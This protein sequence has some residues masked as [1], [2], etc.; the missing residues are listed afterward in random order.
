M[1]VDEQVEEVAARALRATG[2]KKRK[3]RA[4][5]R[6]FLRWGHRWAALILGVL[7]VVITTSG[8]ILL[9]KPEIF[10]FTHRDLFTSTVSAQQIDIAT[11]VDI[12]NKFD[13]D[14]K[15]TGATLAQGVYVVSGADESGPAVFI[16]PGTG[17]V[18]GTGRDAGGFIGV[19]DNLHECALTCQDYP[20]YVAWMADTPL[21]FLA[22]KS[23]YNGDDN[24][25]VPGWQSLSEMSI[26]NMI[27]GSLGLLL[28]LLAVSGIPL[29]WLSFR[30][31]AQ[32]WRVRWRKGRFARDFDLHKV[33]GIVAVP[34]LLM[35]AITG[36]AFEFPFVEDAWYAATGS[37]AF[38]D[39]AHEFSS[40]D[41]KGPDITLAQA[42]AAATALAGAD[43]QI[44]IAT[45]PEADDATSAYTFRL[46]QDID[47]YKY[48]ERPGNIDVSVDRHD[49]SRAEITAGPPIS[50]L[51]QDLWTKWNFPV[52]AGQPVNGWWRSIWF[53]FGLTPIL[54]M[55]TGISTWLYKRKTRKSR[56]QAAAS[57]LDVGT[58][59]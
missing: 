1:S 58:P 10:E 30:R 2:H 55:V 4:P 49:P 12:A 40:N 53:A 56:R 17:L 51:S 23:F 31:F 3:R 33:V 14:L 57:R 11:A 48:G 7:L 29:W 9:Y 52:H 19:L 42:S 36:S 21:G 32:G 8:S 46:A 44:V 35:W 27:L 34:F 20:A 5:V 6:G 50:T 37:P 15:A 41:S 24:Q 25:P 16:D 43:S 38:D 26:G 39:D 45:L 54:L 59:A 28:F 18:N 22:D 13:P 47:P